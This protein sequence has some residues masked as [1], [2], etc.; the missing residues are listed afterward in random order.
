MSFVATKALSVVTT[1]AL[2]RLLLPSDFGIVALGTLAMT[3]MSLFSGMGLGSALVLRQDLDR[4]AQGTVFTLLLVSAAAAA[5][6]LAALSPLIAK[7]FDEPRLTSVLIAMAGVVV[8]GGVCWFYESVLQRELEFRK[9]FLTQLAR[10]IAYA[11]VTLSLAAL[12]AGVWS[13]VAGQLAQFAAYALALFVVAPYRVRPRFNRS[14]AREA[15]ATGGGFM[16]QGG[17]AFLQQNADYLAI[18]RTLGTSELGLYSMAYQQAE[19]P[20]LAIA[21]PMATV[22][23]PAFARM[24]E[25]G[26]DIL[27]AFL[28]SLRLVTLAGAPFAVILSA[29]AEPLTEALLG[30]RWLPMVGALAVLGV[31]GIVRPLETTFGWLLNSIGKAN[32]LALVSLGSLPPLVAGVFFAAKVGGITGVAWVMLAHMGATLVALMLLTARVAG[33][34]LRRQ[35]RALAPLAAAG[36]ASWVA[37]RALTDALG[38]APASLTLTASAAGGLAAYIGV[39]APLEP[40]LLRQLPRQLKRAMRRDR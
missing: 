31:R 16:L 9:R 11:A 14:T 34:T 26:E 30:D 25:R 21:D 19:L 39:L 24:R 38:G 23:F 17:A 27:P 1:I 40:A 7:V 20:A 10:T 36:V 5:V 15:V 18:G 35:C 2:A 29:A 12:G 32:L 13:L 37:T 6:L 33:L 28:S 22:T 3:L 4:R 8:L